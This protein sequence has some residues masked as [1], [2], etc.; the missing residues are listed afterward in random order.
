MIKSK[1]GSA[2][3]YKRQPHTQRFASSKTKPAAEHNGRID[4]VRACKLQQSDKLFFG[5]ILGGGLGLR[6]SE[7]LGVRWSRID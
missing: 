1:S 5:I 7:A 2:D 4:A 6:R 3:V